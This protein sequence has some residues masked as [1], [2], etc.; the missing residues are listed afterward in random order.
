M[1]KYQYSMDYK[2][3]TKLTEL[4]DSIVGLLSEILI[5]IQ[6]DLSYRISEQKSTLEKAKSEVSQHVQWT[7]ELNEIS[8]LQ[9][10][11]LDRQ[12]EQFEELQRVLVRV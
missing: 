11:R 5:D 4:V 7:T 9:Q 8:E 10:S 6:S 3:R 1:K 12:I 2:N